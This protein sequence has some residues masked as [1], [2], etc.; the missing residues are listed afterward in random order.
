[1]H[2]S[3]ME[4]VS[5]AYFGTVFLPLLPLSKAVDSTAEKLDNRRWDTGH[6]ICFAVG[7]T[8]Y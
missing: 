7:I 1:M 2:A 8:G 6:P 3:L 4:D 5:W